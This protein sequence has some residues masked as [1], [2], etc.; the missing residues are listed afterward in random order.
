MLPESCNLHLLSRRFLDPQA[1]RITGFIVKNFGWHFLSDKNL[2]SVRMNIALPNR[3]FCTDGNVLS[4]HD[5][6]WQPSAICDLSTENVADATK[7]LNFN[8]I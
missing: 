4:L 5:P 8:L 7:E 3:T 1:G 2:S 6:A